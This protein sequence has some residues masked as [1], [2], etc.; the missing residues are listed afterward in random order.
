MAGALRSRFRVRSAAG[1]LTLLALINFLNYVDRMIL[2]PLVEILK[3]PVHRGGLGLTSAQAGL[4]QTAF[5]VVHSVA[6]IPLG[7]VAD[8]Y[9]RRY[10]IAIGVGVWSV[11]TTL[12]GFARTFAQLFAARAAVGIGEATYAPAASALISERFPPE[13]RARALGIFQLGMGLGSAAGYFAGAFIAPVFGWRAAFFVVG[14]PGLLLVASMFLVDDETMACPARAAVVE[15]AAREKLGLALP[16]WI[17]ATGVLVTFFIGAVG[18]W[19]MPY[20]L[21]AHFDGNTHRMGQVAVQFGIPAAIATLSGMIA[22]A[23]AADRLERLKPGVGRLITIAVSVLIGVPLAMVGI[24][25]THKVPQILVIS[26]GVFFL[27]WYVGP[28]L[29][30]LHESVPVRFRGTATG[31]YFFAVHALGD[32]ISPPIVGMLDDMTGSLRP[33]LLLAVAL[34][35]IGGLCCVAAIASVR[36]AP[37]LKGPPNGE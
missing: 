34:A 13:R 27:A 20:V 2:A 17:I 24:L 3:Q 30:A 12:A 26:A 25:L 22:G 16:A 23:V 1:L 6:S 31:I 11:A 35:A 5:M 8:R 36:R 19:G 10:L 18:F 37:E 28:I 15:P 4:L 21:R 7:Y 9:A 32:G 33:G 29:A 14:L